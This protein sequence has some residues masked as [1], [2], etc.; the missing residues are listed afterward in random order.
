MFS[1]VKGSPNYDPDFEKQWTEYDPATANKLLD[2]LGLTKGSDGMR[3]RSDG[4]A[5]ENRADSQ[6]LGLRHQPRRS[7]SH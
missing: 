3:K 5:L 4:K 1:P 7:G 2:D 6:R